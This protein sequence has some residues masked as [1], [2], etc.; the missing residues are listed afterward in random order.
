MKLIGGASLD[1]KLGDYVADRDPAA[2]LVAK[3]AEAV[4]HAHTRG[5][6]H[7]DLKPGNVLID[8][9]GEPHVTDFGLAKRL[10][11]DSEIT[12]SGAILGTPAYM[13]PEQASGKRE[14]VTTATDIYGLGAILYA[15]LTGRAPFVGDSAT[16]TL[17]H[18][19][20]R[21]PEAP[22]KRRPHVRATWK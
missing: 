10:Q 7:R 21:A 14:A 4:H 20:E 16:E 3:V 9:L 1:R 17:Q 2:V 22:T 18:V 8:E 15:L 5:I 19:R 13:A 11:G 6:L 12:Q